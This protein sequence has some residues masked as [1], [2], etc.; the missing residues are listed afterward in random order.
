M[1]TNFIS[2]F[3]RL[4][5]VM[6]ITITIATFIV[7]S[8]PNE[9][10][11]I[12]IK[13]VEFQKD[14][15]TLIDN[16]AGLEDIKHLY[17][18]KDKQ[19][20]AFDAIKYTIEESSSNEYY[21]KNKDSLDFILR[22]IKTNL[23]INKSKYINKF[24]NFNSKLKLLIKENHEKNPFDVLDEN[25]K[26]YFINLRIKLTNSNSYDDVKNDI[27][28][29]VTELSEKNNTIKEYLADATKSYYISIFAL[30][31]TILFGLYPAIKNYKKNNN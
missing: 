7:K 23:F 3:L 5:I 21:F 24:D 29:I 13:K 16:N 4:C 9:H 12:I 20:N 28:K 27:Y 22:D 18:S 14:I 19:P 15:L 6:I 1:F 11:I 8:I 26:E 31:I 30:V 17:N 10:K 2:E 25:Q